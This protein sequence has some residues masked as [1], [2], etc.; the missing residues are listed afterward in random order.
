VED[1]LELIQDVRVLDVIV[2]GTDVLVD[3][4]GGPDN[5]CG[6]I[7]FTFPDEN[8]RHRQEALLRWWQRQG[9]LLAFMVEG[10]SVTLTNLDAFRG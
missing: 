8:D 1:E 9:T 7:R 10:S 4:Y 5:A 2:D 6:S 3:I